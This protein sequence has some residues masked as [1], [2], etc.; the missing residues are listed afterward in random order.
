MP[1]LDTGGL[2]WI[3]GASSGIG[4]ALALYMAKRGHRVVVSARR[5]EAL[6]ELAAE[7][8]NAK[9][10]LYPLALD[11]TDAEKA[12]E[13]VDRIEAE[14][15]EIALAV[16][17]AG[18]HIPLDIEDFSPEPFRKLLDV[19]VMGVV[20]GLSPLIERMRERRRGHL[21]VV[22]SL[23]GYC[24]LPS[25]SAYGLTKAGLINMCE[26]LQPELALYGIKLQ[27]VNPGFVRTPLTDRNDFEMPFLMELDDAVRAFYDGLQSDTFEIVFPKRMACALGS[28]RRLPYRL[29]FKMTGNMA[30][31]RRERR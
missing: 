11:V 19:N 21:A 25:A 28:M 5:E 3:T 17:N 18:T 22:A 29:F 2:V 16:L 14:H 4:R 1:R 26:A 13:A 31:Q 15:G 8:E 6:Q 30:K 23:A 27:L 7:A 10:A 12:R 20:N 9:G 24:G